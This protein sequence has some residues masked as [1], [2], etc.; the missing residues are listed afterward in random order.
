MEQ[1]RQWSPLQQKSSGSSRYLAKE[2]SGRRRFR[3]S[4]EQSTTEYADEV[5]AAAAVK[6]QTMIRVDAAAQQPLALTLAAQAEDGLHLPC[7]VTCRNNGNVLLLR[8][9][10]L[11][12]HALARLNFWHCQPA[13]STD[14]AKWQNPAAQQGFGRN[15]CRVAGLVP[16]GYQ[17]SL[18][19]AI[20]HPKSNRNSVSS[21]QFA[22]NINVFILFFISLHLSY[23]Q[24]KNAP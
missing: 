2:I 14:H 10:N 22:C 13:N 9:G 18:F 3:R 24:D 4:N 8:H 1:H 20:W 21:M 5:A 17:S 6:Q 23:T 12:Y 16:P 7:H 11:V 15:V 19:A